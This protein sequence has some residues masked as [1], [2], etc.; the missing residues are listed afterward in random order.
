M[1]AFLSAFLLLAALAAASA[2]PSA[3]IR[4]FRHKRPVENLPANGG[5]A[6]FSLNPGIFSHAQPGLADL[7]LYRE[8]PGNASS[9]TPYVVRNAAPV[10]AAQGF[11]ELLNKGLRGGQTGFDAAMPHWVLDG[12]L[13]AWI[14]RMKDPAVRAR[15]VKEMR[16]P[17]PGFESVLI[18]SGPQGA[19]LLQFKS[20][21][22]KPLT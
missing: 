1:R 19:R 9:E 20:D 12:G 10:A 7:R 14:A 11:I 15:L 21:A 4:Y 3:E 22:L 13:E 6:C 5:Q 2:P 16:D 18:A 17:P 8:G